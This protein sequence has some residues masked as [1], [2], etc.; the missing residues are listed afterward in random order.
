MRRENEH[1]R[2]V[3]KGETLKITTGRR[4]IQ[5]QVLTGRREDDT[6]HKGSTC[7][8]DYVNLIMQRTDFV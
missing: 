6:G 5:N 1:K 8:K 7:I 3:E 4:T 2:M